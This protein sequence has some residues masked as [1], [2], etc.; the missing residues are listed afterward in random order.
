[1][2]DRWLLRIAALLSVLVALTTYRF[3]AMPLE[4][5]FSVMVE[6]ITNRKALFLMHISAAPIALVIGTFQVMPKVRRANKAVHRWL[7]RIYALAILIAGIG[8]LGIGLTAIGGPVAQVGFSALAVAWLGTTA[9]AVTLA[10]QGHFAQH[11][12]W[13]I[14]SFALTFAA[15]TLR[16]QIVGF[17]LAGINYPDASL[18]LAY[19]CWIPNF[20]VAEWLIRTRPK[21]AI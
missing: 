11:R 4:L 7:G 15:V 10:M 5:A 13:M 21:I 20:M 19:T 6:H 3:F 9:W 18:W 1:M 14:R 16:L 8:G 17:Q 12:V 2:T